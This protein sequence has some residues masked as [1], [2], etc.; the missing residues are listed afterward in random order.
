MTSSAP[1]IR[2]STLLALRWLVPL[3]AIAAF[4]GLPESNGTVAFTPSEM[5]VALALI[6]LALIVDIR[7][8]QS[9]RRARKRPATLDEREVEAELLRSARERTQLIYAMAATLNTTLNYEK[10]LNALLDIGVL[11][12][13]ELGENNRL[14]SAVLLFQGRDLRVA[15]ARGF[16]GQD[17]RTTVPAQ[18]GILGIAVNQSEP[19][20]GGEARSDPELQYYSGLIKTKSLLALPL[21]AGFNKYGVLLF[22]SER[23]NAFS[24]DHIE[25]LNAL[26]TQATIALQNAILYLKLLEERDKLIE[27]EEDARKKLARDLHDGPVQL[28][29]A[30]AMRANMLRVMVDRKPEILPVELAKIEDLARQAT[31]EIRHTLFLLRPLA[32]ETQGL[33]AAL[34][35]MAEKMQETYGQSVLIETAANVE[36]LLNTNQQSVIFYIVEEAV[37]NARKHAESEHIWVRIQPRQE[38]VLVEIQDKGKGFDLGSVERGYEKR[39]SLGMVNMRE[40]AELIEATVDIDS[41]EGKG[42]RIS[43]LVP[44]KPQMEATEALE[45]LPKEQKHAALP[46]RSVQMP[47]RIRRI[48]TGPLRS[49]DDPNA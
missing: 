10:V 11:G 49:P 33:P 42:T 37:N 6:L 7:S 17:E 13:R 29:S 3:C 21:R 8:F 41:A 38:L 30:V 24:D 4:I 16:T 23:A 14:A 47:P 12:L 35:Q 44:K 20:F 34:K 5:V 46:S 19:V 43:L 40:R 36:T 9:E 25:L 2:T 48:S 31:K 15:A 27:V 18:R 45:S 39:G 22:G 32:L 28:V 1:R 26:G